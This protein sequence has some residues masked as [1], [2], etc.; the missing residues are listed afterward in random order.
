MKV[1]LVHDWLIHMRGGEK[2]LE[3][4]AEIFP[5]AT[6]Y[7][8][9]SNRSKL[10]PSL[11][12]MRIKNSWLHYLPG[13]RSYYGWLLP[14]L[15]WVIG[16]LQ[17]KDA[18]LVISSS[19]CVAKGIR[20][21]KDAVHICYCHTP[22][23]YLWGFESQYFEKFPKG[24][25]RILEPLLQRLRE[26][27]VAAAKN[28]NHF[29]CNSE[30]VR[31]RI[32]KIYGR[33]AAVIHPPVEADFFKPNSAQGRK[34]YYLIVSAMTPYKRVDLAVEAFNHWDRDLILAG[35]GPEL[36][37]CQ[38]KAQTPNIRFFGKVSNEKLEEL[39]AHAQALIFPQEE[40][41]GIV[42][43]EAQAC[44]TPVIAFARGGAL[45]SVKDGVFFQ[46]QTPAAIRKA[47]LEFETRK[48]DAESLRRHALQFDK[49]VFKNKIR[50]AIQG[51]V[52]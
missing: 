9:F 31:N 26:W 52:A 50:Q 40:D 38:R 22:M 3:S 44:G 13:I 51:V 21:P 45:E 27:D 35:E 11:Q 29:L 33:E 14:I 5:D 8:L 15:P 30:T 19:H 42:P 24:L 16:T 32:K 49:P 41:F 2:V 20:I 37:S 12:R 47:V 39:Y 48:I 10:S 28:V 18:D 36:V 17:I 7:T 6:L 43:L 46:E 34:K 4:F 1:A 25:L 23:R